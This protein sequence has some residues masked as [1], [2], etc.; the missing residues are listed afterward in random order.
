VVRE[1]LEHDRLVAPSSGRHFPGDEMATGLEC[2]EGLDGLD[3]LD[4]ADDSAEP[5]PIRG[6]AG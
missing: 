1:A 5:P 6:S 3:T 4:S 2:L